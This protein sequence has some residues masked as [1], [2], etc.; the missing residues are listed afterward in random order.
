VVD[1]NEWSREIV[2]PAA[3]R[4]KS[5]AGECSEDG[6]SIAARTAAASDTMWLSKVESH[7]RLLRAIDFSI[8]AL[9]AEMDT[10]QIAASAKV[11]S[12]SRAPVGP[13]Q[14]SSHKKNCNLSTFM[15]HLPL[16]I[17]LLLSVST[18]LSDKDSALKQLKK[19]IE[20]DS[21]I[22]NSTPLSGAQTGLEGAIAML[23][24]TMDAFIRENRLIP[25]TRHHF[26]GL[27]VQALRLASRT[28]S[29]GA[30]FQA[31]QE[32]IDP[33]SVLLI[34]NSKLATPLSI[35]LSLGNNMHGDK[36]LSA[37]GSGWKYE[38]GLICDINCSTVFDLEDI[39][40]GDGGQ[41]A[42][43]DAAYKC[44]LFLK[45]DLSDRYP[46]QT[47]CKKSDIPFTKIKECI[48]LSR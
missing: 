2:S 12:S 25:L 43:V 24:D 20:R 19:D 15:G 38:W 5:R 39:S 37:D 8:A 29:G 46:I 10:Y 23:C 6:A 44:T 41:R 26:E 45:L 27:S 11:P 13:P 31:L 34:P 18:P 16:K 17:S 14:R 21:L 42:A 7:M 32:C 48:H 33:D 28:H 4:S 36:D 9:E 47:T 1:F 22:I 3:F 35:K 40:S 30:A